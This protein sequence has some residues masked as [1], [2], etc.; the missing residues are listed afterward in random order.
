MAVTITADELAA[1]CNGGDQW[2]EAEKTRMLALATA[3][4][5]A[6][7]VKKEAPDALSNEYAIRVAAF[8]AQSRDSLGQLDL[9]ARSHA[10]DTARASGARA[11]VAPYLKF[12]A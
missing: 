10:Q 12:G 11:L 3:V 6:E 8:L 4:Y 7:G 2:S 1:L 5:E 9:N